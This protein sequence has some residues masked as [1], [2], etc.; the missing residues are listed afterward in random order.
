MN[1][2]KKKLLVDVKPHETQTKERL[3]LLESQVKTLKTIVYHR[4]TLQNTLQIVID[5][6]TKRRD[7]HDLSKFIDDEFNGFAAIG[8][9]QFRSSEYDE[10]LKSD[11]IQLHYKL[12]DHH[13]EHYGDVAD[14]G[15]LQIIEMTCDWFAAWSVYNANG[16]N[17]YDWITNVQQ[18]FVR[19]KT[20]FSDWQ[21]E[22]IDQIAN[23]IHDVNV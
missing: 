21:I 1:K 11:T 23:L 18:Q 4:T 5:A 13:P 22:V 17:D 3:D 2:E 12:N 10:A 6:L 19:Y 9:M 7:H 20:S 14:M 8:Q 15:V 16:K